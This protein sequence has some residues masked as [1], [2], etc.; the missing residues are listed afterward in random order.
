MIPHKEDSE[1]LD[2]RDGRIW[3]ENGKIL[4]RRT[5]EN[6]TWQNIGKEDS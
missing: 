3:K 2:K 6:W 1:I 5:A 4:A